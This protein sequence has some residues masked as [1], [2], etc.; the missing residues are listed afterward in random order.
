MSKRPVLTALAGLAATVGLA[1]SAAPASAAYS[2][3]PVNR[4]C[5]W[6]NSDFQGARADLADSDGNLADELFNDGPAGRNGWNVQVENNAASVAN[7]TGQGAYIYDGRGCTG[8]EAFVS[9][10]SGRTLGALKNR[11][12]SVW[13]VAGPNV[14]CANI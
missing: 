4:F 1:A 8:A 11:V 6:F 7:R 5:L 10:N 9:G 13:V 14:G 3:C 2:E 12:S